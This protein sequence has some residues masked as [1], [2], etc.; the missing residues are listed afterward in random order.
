LYFYRSRFYSPELK[1]FISEDSIGIEGGLNVYAYVDANPISVIDPFGEAPP[2]TRG[3]GGPPTYREIFDRLNEIQ[4]VRQEQYEREFRERERT[5]EQRDKEE[6]AERY[7]RPK[8][9]P[10][11]P[12][13]VVRENA[14]GAGKK[15]ELERVCK[16]FPWL[17]QCK[18]VEKKPQNYCPAL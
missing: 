14:T 13:E 8:P 16:L 5:R 17:E 12:E 1:R 7:G 4:R 15:T 2:R 9:P 18:A 10:P 6:Y 11:L 3:A